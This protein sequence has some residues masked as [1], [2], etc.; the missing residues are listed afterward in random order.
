MFLGKKLLGCLLIFALGLASGH[1]AMGAE[2]SVLQVVP[3]DVLGVAVV[4][5][6]EAAQG[7]VEK[8]LVDLKLPVPKALGG[9]REQLRDVKG[10]DGTGNFAAAAVPTAGAG[11]TMVLFAAVTDFDQF[12]QSVKAA[13]AVDG[14]AK[15]TVGGRPSLIAH[16][17]GYVL[18]TDSSGEAALKA[19]LQA[20]KH[21]AAEVKPLADRIAQT[22]AY[23]LATPAGIKMAQQQLLAGLA[24]AKAMIE[25]QGG[26]QAKQ[27]AM[28]LGL[29]ESMFQSLDKE[30]THALIGGRLE[31]SGAVRVVMGAALT[32]QGVLA[33]LGAAAEAPD[34]DLLAGLPREDFVFAGGGVLPQQWSEHLADFSMTAMKI[35]FGAADLDEQQ[36]QALIETSKKSMEGMRSMSMLMGVTGEGQP[37]YSKTVLL[38]K[39][40]DSAEYLRNYAVAMEEMKQLTE[41]MD[42]PPFSYDV[43]KIDIAG[44]SGLCIRMD[45][46]GM[47]EM[48]GAPG[49][50]QME[51]MF[52]LMFGEGGQVSVYMAPKDAKTVIGTYIC[53]ERLEQ[54]LKQ[55]AVE[56][57]SGEPTVAKTLDLLPKNSHAV[58][59]WS[60]PGTVRLVSQ[61]LRTVQPQIADSLP[62]FPPTPPVGF[63]AS[64]SGTRVDLDIVIPGEILKA[65]AELVQ[66]MQAQQVR[67]QSAV[68]VE[69]I[70]PSAPAVP[71]QP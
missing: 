41:R 40:E 63:A 61:I 47:M 48:A 18:L 10:L 14:V 7:Q 22:G 42:K 36:M 38:I 58:G 29:Y 20:D 70:A 59:L 19:V 65:V 21:L 13:E 39:V 27:T 31:P 69:P 66:Q 12:C 57:L 35:Y 8:L 28:A 24:A 16:K 15:A 71:A 2:G 45:M 4:K 43:E 46:K 26:E 30:L 52:E 60:V 62:E 64:L 49:Q 5:N 51:N 3:S 56:P 25:Q 32:K 68:P 37:L 33:K 23:A 54:L 1:A 55:D 44:K 11:P 6:P 50:P 34:F 53:K 17:G 67:A 9:M